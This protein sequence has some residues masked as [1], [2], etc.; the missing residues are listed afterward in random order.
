MKNAGISA[1]ALDN[2]VE[3]S[4]MQGGCSQ[5]S[6]LSLAGN[7]ELANTTLGAK[8]SS[9]PLLPVLNLNFSTPVYS[10]QVRKN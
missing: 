4:V 1:H 5:C 9:W 7:P 6:E 3:N 8:F 10:T 2:F